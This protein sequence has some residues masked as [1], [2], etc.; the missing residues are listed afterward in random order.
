MRLAPTRCI[1][2][3]KPP[4]DICQL[5]AA[6]LERL[7]LT[8]RL[9]DNLF[10]PSNWHQSLSDRFEDEPH[11][12]EQLRRAGEKIDARAVRFRMD[13]IESQPGPDGTH[14][15]FRPDRTPR[16]FARLL[17]NIGAA[18]TAT[19]G[20]RSVQ[21]TAHV[22]ISYWAREHLRRLVEIQPV[23]WVLDEVLLV[24]GGGHP[25]HY[26]VLDRWPLKAPSV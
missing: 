24:R 8:A 7:G 1:L 16:D 18:V 20:R 4:A 6:E 9:G 2:L 15:A 26:E 5:L 13:R 11:V 25:Y 10:A 14:W 3:G 19:T 21:P 22:T 17:Q 23:E 12:V